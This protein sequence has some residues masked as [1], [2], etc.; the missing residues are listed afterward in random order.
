MPRRFQFA[1]AVI[2]ER[3][4]EEKDGVFSALRLV[5]NFHIPENFPEN[6]SVKFHV[7]IQLKAVPVPKESFRITAAIINPAGQRLALP[8]PPEP[9]KVP[10]D[11]D[12]TVPGG[13]S[14]I[15]Q[16]SVK[17]HTLGT[18]FLVIEVDGEEEVRVPFTLRRKSAVAPA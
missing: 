8:P 12:P 13:V 4:I 5:D 11:A 9:F 10:E 6:A 15:F 18:Y 3:I 7:V 2:C 1:S 14:L 16:V 17:P